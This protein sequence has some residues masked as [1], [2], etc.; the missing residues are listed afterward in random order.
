MLFMQISVTKKKKLKMITE[1]R[2]FI[3]S[4]SDQEKRRHLEVS[5]KILSYSEGANCLIEY[6]IFGNEIFGN[7]RNTF[8]MF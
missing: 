7:F 4:L 3:H 8:K 5:T 1:K 6:L 2:H